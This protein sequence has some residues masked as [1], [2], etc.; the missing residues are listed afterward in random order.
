MVPRPGGQY[1]SICRAVVFD[2]E[3]ELRVASAEK[4]EVLQKRIGPFTS[5]IAI[6]F[7]LFAAYYRMS[8][9]SA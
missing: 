7:T 5:F 3:D 9:I 2:R 8:L 4:S 1:N 6:F